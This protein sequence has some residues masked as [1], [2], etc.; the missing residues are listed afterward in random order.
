MVENK[1]KLVGLLPPFGQ[2]ADILWGKNAAIDSDGNSRTAK[3]NDWNELTLILR[4]D[5]N[6]RLDIDPDSQDKRYLLIRSEK[7]V[8]VSKTINF[9]RQYRSIE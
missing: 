5:R 3:S 8:L 7:N 2:I 9:L 1:V 4:K 6:Q